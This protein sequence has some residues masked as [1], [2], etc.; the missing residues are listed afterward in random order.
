MMCFIELD[1]AAFVHLLE[2]TL[3]TW[4]EWRPK[5][6][7]SPRQKLTITASR[8]GRS[9]LQ[10]ASREQHWSAATAGQC[11]GRVPATVR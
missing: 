8:W 9:K 10:A 5:T 1:P 2:P 4:S 3:S 11:A 6:W 7:E